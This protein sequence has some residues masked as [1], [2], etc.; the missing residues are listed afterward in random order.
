MKKIKLSAVAYSIKIRESFSIC[1]GYVVLIYVKSRR[2]PSG[3]YIRSIY[4]VAVGSNRF[5]VARR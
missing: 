2:Y 5:S 1:H 4:K 3:E